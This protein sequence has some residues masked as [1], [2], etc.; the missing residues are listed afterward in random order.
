MSKKSITF[1]SMNTKAVN[2]L[3]AFIIGS[4]D[5]IKE[6]SRFNKQSKPIKAKINEILLNREKAIDDGMDYNHA[7]ELYST[8]AESQELKNLKDAH[9]KKVKTLK[10]K[11]DKALDL[12]PESLYNSYV[13]KITLN[14]NGDFLSDVEKFLEN[15]GIENNTQAG[16]RNISEQLNNRIG[17]KL[18]TSKTIRENG[19]LTTLLTENQF[20]KLFIS[21]FIDILVNAKI[22]GFTQEDV[23]LLCGGSLEKLEK[24]DEKPVVK[25]EKSTVKAE[26]PAEKPIEKTA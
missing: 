22:A 7:I 8:F 12:I 10:S 11:I 24:E 4:T 2:S 5:L 25:A 13:K 16:I 26:K 23:I 14:K 9:S 3:Q 21:S 20:N 6:N 15:T 1:K 18:S 19:N 17:C